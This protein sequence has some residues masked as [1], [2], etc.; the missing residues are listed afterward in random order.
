MI[1]YFFLPLSLQVLVVSQFCHV[2]PIAAQSVDHHRPN[3]LF[4]LTDDQP[5]DYLSCTGNQVVQT[6]NIDALA[7]EGMLFTN[8]Y[9]TSAI[10]TPSR[11]SYL[12]SQFERRHS[13]NFNS[14]TSV[15]AEAWRHSYPVLLRE[16]GYYTGYVG[17]NHSPV[18]EGG[19]QGGLMEQSFDF[20]YAAHGHLTFYPKSRHD[21]FNDAKANTQIE[22][23]EEGVQA[24]MDNEHQLTNAIRF[25]KDRPVDQPFALTV[26]LNLPHNA[27]TSSMKMLPDDPEIYRSLFRNQKIP[28]P[29]HYRAKE[30]ITDPRLPADLLRTRDRQT[31]YDYVDTPA[32]L[33]ERYT[34]HMQAMAGIDRLIG[35]LRET[36]HD[37]DL[38]K[39]TVII[40]ASDH[41][42]FNGQFGLGGKA[43]CYEIC[44]HI[45]FIIFDPRNSKALQIHRS[46][47]LVQSIDVAPTM[48]SLAGIPI[49]AEFQGR[50][51][52]PLLSGDK[53]AVRTYLFTENLWSTPFGNPR[54]E[55]VRDDRWKYIRYY[56]NNTTSARQIESLARHLDLQKSTM[57]YGIHDSDI[58]VYRKYIES[59]LHGEEPVYEELFDLQSDP[60]EV[61]N[62]AKNTDMQPILA[63]MRM[64]WKRQIVL[65][66]G[67][68]S[69]KVERYTIDSKNAAKSDR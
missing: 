30:E 8:A 41:G 13:V 4:V 59:P 22:I 11:V 43:L 34:R 45:P 14:G 48:L 24:F 27:G 56:K 46:E 17:K 2:M 12:L 54:C 36:L 19:Y 42:I 66:R 5:Y 64:A 6:P 61:F 23:I 44:T 47:A 7:N 9:V 57:L 18:G 29:P 63:N 49:P 15:S 69:P 51:L 39:N 28:L 21:I 58:P 35:V 52:S 68:G 38:A 67:E 37:L 55:A 32:S 10:C 33:R 65:A 26:C 31:S 53:G 25:V 20:W 16:A 3:F 60:L 50:D 40:F 62:V 1:N